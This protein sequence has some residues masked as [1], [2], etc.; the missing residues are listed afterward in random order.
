MPSLGLCT[1]ICV[2][3]N[4]KN[5][6]IEYLMKRLREGRSLCHLGAETGFFIQTIVGV[7]K[8][9]PGECSLVSREAGRVG[10][11]GIMPRVGA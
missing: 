10:A 9:K 7:M 11:A 8:G 3:K 6:H 4:I 1:D 2:D 5:I